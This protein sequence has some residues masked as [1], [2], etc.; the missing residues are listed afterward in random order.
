MASHIPVID[1]F[2]GPGGLGEGFSSLVHGKTRFRIHLSVEKDPVAHK[3][4][5][6]R[7]FYRQFNV[8]GLEAPDAY[9]RYLK[10]LIS[11]GELA[12]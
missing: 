4:L 11:Y 3:T 8:V 5:A 7:A 12:A 6:L 1:L 9:Y 2:A 10:G